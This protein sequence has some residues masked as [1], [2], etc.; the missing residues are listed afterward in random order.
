[1]TGKR[2]PERDDT[3][4]RIDEALFNRRLELISDMLDELQ[5][6]KDKLEAGAKAKTLKDADAA[7]NKFRIM[8]N[9]IQCMGLKSSE[10]E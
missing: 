6:M 2:N 9:R 4:N 5:L 10:H 7:I 1:M 8:A 3:M